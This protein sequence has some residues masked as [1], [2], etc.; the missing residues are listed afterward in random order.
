MSLGAQ[1]Q[2]QTQQQYGQ[3][4]ERPAAKAHVGGLAV[5][6]T[7]FAAQHARFKLRDL[8]DDAAIDLGN[9]SDT[10]VGVPQQRTSQL[11]RAHPGDLH[12]LPGAD[13]GAEP[14]VVGDG[15]QEVGIGID[16]AAYLLREDDLVA[17]G[18]GKLEPLGD[19]VW[20]YFVTPAEGGHRQVEEGGDGA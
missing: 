14:G 5:G 16:V 20:L 19:Q 13:A 7:H 1:R 10:G 17:D 9:D 8:A 18:G 6:G 3:T 11:Q 4:V 2:R 15:Q 12:V